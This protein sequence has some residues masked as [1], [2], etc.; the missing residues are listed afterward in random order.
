VGAKRVIESI[1][2]PSPYLVGPFNMPW[3]TVVFTHL[4]T[5]INHMLKLTPIFAPARK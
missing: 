3:M 4:I 5:N 1:F 2:I